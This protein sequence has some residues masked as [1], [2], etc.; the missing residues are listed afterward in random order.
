M[1]VSEAEDEPLPK[2]RVGCSLNL[3]LMPQLEGSQGAIAQ[4]SAIAWRSTVYT[5]HDGAWLAAI[6][7]GD[8]FRPGMIRKQPRRLLLDIGKER[9][10]LPL[11]FSIDACP[12][13]ATDHVPWPFRDDFQQTILYIRHFVVPSL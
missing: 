4:D 7:E 11:R 12:L 2:R 6:G 13:G 10:R 5:V 9:P 8:P 1:Q 3:L